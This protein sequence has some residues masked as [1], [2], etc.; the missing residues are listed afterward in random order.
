MR[1][2]N[3]PSEPESK[4]PSNIPARTQEEIVIVEG[5]LRAMLVLKLTCNLPVE[6]IIGVIRF[7][8]SPPTNG[9]ECQ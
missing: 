2:T 9:R 6:E 7:I 5:L 8:D 4:F 3:A 1:H